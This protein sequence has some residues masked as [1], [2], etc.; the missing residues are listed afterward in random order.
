MA[1]LSWTRGRPAG[2]VVLMAQQQYKQK[3][4]VARRASL[5]LIFSLVVWSAF[6]GAAAQDGRPLPSSIGVASMTEDGTI[7]LQL[8]AEGEQGQV[9]DALLIYKPG[10]PMYEEVKRHLGGIR[11]GEHKPVPPWPDAQ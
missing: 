4:A 9:G 6:A 2:Y 1:A 3:P 7:W 8:R 10:D 5:G 11:P